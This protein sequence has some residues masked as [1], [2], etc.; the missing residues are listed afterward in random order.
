VAQVAQ[1]GNLPPWLSPA[2]GR[3]C[4]RITKKG[5]PKTAP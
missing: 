2:W 4:A 3:I 1:C 5:G